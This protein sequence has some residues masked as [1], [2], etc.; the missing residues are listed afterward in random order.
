MV[1][2]QEA[3]GDTVV[4]ESFL[5]D[6]S[7]IEE[8]KREA[9]RLARIEF[10]NL[11][12]KVLAVG[13]VV[14]I[15]FLFTMSMVRHSRVLKAAAQK[16][17]ETQERMG[18]LPEG[19]AAGPQEPLPVIPTEEDFASLRKQ[20]EEVAKQSPEKIAKVIKGLIAGT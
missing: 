16:V 8:E 7:Y 10:R 15:L 1:G 14:V 20:I 19:V 5:F 18:P 17:Q 3:R 12:V 9:S 13:L 2:I 4:V 6:K 11:M